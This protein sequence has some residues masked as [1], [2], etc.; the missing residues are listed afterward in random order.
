MS[1]FLLHPIHALDSPSLNCHETQTTLFFFGRRSACPRSQQSPSKTL[2][3]P[4]RTLETG[5]GGTPPVQNPLYFQYST[6]ELRP[7]S[8]Y[9]D[10]EQKK[11]YR[12]AFRYLDLVM[13]TQDKIRK[14]QNE[15]EELNRMEWQGGSASIVPSLTP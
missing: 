13:R 4:T 5:R 2:H 11:G 9:P 3:T 15:L 1:R 14:I 6:W 10:K 7:R 8:V 12:A